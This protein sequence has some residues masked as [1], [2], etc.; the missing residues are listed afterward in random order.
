MTAPIP[1]CAFAGGATIVRAIAPTNVNA[2][3]RRTRVSSKKTKR[4]VNRRQ[5]SFMLELLRQLTIPR[6][7]PISLQAAE[8]LQR[9][10]SE[11]FAPALNTSPEAVDLDYAQG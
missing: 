4:F 6:L 5:R 7:R 2:I 3:A 8:R 10:R 11:I 1:I 9:G